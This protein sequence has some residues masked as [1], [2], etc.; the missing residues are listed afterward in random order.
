MENFSDLSVRI[1]TSYVLAHG[2]PMAEPEVDWA[3]GKYSHLKVLSILQQEMDQDQ[4]L[5]KKGEEDWPSDE[6]LASKGRDSWLNPCKG[7][8]DGQREAGAQKH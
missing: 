2:F 3:R 7:M 5:Q 4:G 6:E 8:T 1:N